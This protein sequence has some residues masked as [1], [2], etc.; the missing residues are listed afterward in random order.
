MQ[1]VTLTSESHNIYIE[2]RKEQTVRGKHLGV[3]GEGTLFQSTEIFIFAF[4][5][6][7]VQLEFIKQQLMF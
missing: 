7:V 1:S 5:I 3:E 6:F 4:I 2:K